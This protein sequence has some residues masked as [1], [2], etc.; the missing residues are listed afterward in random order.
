MNYEYMTSGTNRPKGIPYIR[1][2]FFYAPQKWSDSSEA[3]LLTSTVPLKK[4]DL[5]FKRGLYYRSEEWQNY[6]DDFR[7]KKGTAKVLAMQ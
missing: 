1:P 7:M 2:Q 3:G 5:R 6:I 4:E